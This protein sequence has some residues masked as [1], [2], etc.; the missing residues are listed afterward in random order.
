M[1]QLELACAPETHLE[2]VLVLAAL[3]GC[4]HLNKAAAVVA[5]NVGVLQ[6]AGEAAMTPC[7]HR[8]YDEEARFFRSPSIYP[9]PR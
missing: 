6:A 1:Q 7:L 2:P 4:Q 8:R 3:A 5:A 9:E